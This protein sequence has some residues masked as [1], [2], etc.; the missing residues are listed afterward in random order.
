M[1]RGQLE[2]AID[3][4]DEADQLRT[5]TAD[6]TSA[7][8]GDALR[9][10]ISAAR[11]QHAEAIAI[12][13]SVAEE[14]RRAGIPVTL[15]WSIWVR[16]YAIRACGDDE[17]LVAA[18]EDL[19]GAIGVPWVA[20][21]C[22]VVRAEIALA[23]GDL[24]LARRT[25]DA[26]LAATNDLQFSRCTRSRCLLTRSRIHRAS[27]VADAEDVAH[28]A[29]ALAESGDMRLEAIEALELLASF[30][31]DTDSVEYAA[32]LISA[33]TEARQ[34][35]G[36]PAPPRL[37]PEIDLTTSILRDALEP[38]RL[39]ALQD[40]GHALDVTAATAYAERGRGARRRP[41]TGWQSL[42][43]TEQQVVELAATGMKNA[44]IAE[45]MFI[46]IPTVKT[47]LTHIFT[48]LDVT[49][50]AQLAALAA[51]RAL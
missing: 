36:A 1:Q 21:W 24:A 12:A 5:G 26:T 48:K 19:E 35:I 7:L 17:G 39:S 46:S 13:T 41:A 42:T 32:R 23:E 18:V 9:G 37:Q 47:H 49:T 22:G 20:P 6:T 43:P 16:L 10:W 44:H 51:Q 3:M 14:S 31:A 27:G 28:Q 4:L 8:L 50:R 25:I 29:L 15:A 40:E 11:G 33:A 2:R 34:G 38:D 30:G 45:Q